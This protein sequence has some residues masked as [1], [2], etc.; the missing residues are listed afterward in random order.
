MLP[1]Q[2]R[3]RGGPIAS[4]PIVD[5]ESQPRHPLKEIRKYDFVVIVLVDRGIIQYTDL[6]EAARI[7]LDER[8]I[9]RADIEGLCGVMGDGRTNQQ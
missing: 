9:A 5:S 7:K 1:Q 2:P 6:P 3:H 8:A 4:W